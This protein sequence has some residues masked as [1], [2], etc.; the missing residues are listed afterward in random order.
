LWHAR[1]RVRVRRASGKKLVSSLA[2]G[3]VSVNTLISQLLA[4]FT[5]QNQQLKVRRSSI[6]HSAAALNNCDVM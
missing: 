2:A 5:Q 1:A 4:Q 3:T 6:A